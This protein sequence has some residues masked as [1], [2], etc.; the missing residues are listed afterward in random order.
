MD[1]LLEPVPHG[2]RGMT[3]LA[4]FQTVLGE[5][6]PM[7]QRP[8]PMTIGKG[9]T[10]ASWHLPSVL[11]VPAF[12]LCY[13]S[14]FTRPKPVPDLLG[15]SPE[16]WQHMTEWWEGME[17]LQKT[18]DPVDWLLPLDLFP[19]VSKVADFSLSRV[20][21]RPWSETALRRTRS[22]AVNLQAIL[23]KRP[24]FLVLRY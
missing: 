13:T 14:G 8:R 16:S 12:S 10:G 2:Y 9:N 24:D 7:C 11:W 6:N 18:A 15:R 23:F 20:K 17:R 4:I 22:T 1:W 5:R 3:V 21:H 19:S